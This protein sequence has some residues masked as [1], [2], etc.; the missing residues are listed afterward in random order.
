MEK[1]KENI[2]IKVSNSL[3]DHV[4]VIEDTKEFAKVNYNL[5]IR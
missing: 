3:K 5:I 4:K 1:E 2:L